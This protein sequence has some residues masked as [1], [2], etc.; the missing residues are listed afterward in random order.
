MR[1]SL[2]MCRSRRGEAVALPNY[3]SA[4]KGASVVFT[5]NACWTLHRNNVRHG[6]GA[7][8]DDSFGQ[9]VQP[10]LNHIE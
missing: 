2:G 4:R 5:C 6:V 8:D 3:V 9:T 7:P 1:I 10:V